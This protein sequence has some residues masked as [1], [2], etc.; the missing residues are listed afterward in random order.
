MWWRCDGQGLTGGA[1]CL[2]GWY[3][4]TGNLA[5]P[6]RSNVSKRRCAMAD[7]LF[8]GRWCVVDR[9]TASA[10]SRGVGTLNLL[11]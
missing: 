5:F 1:L 8:V 7:M 6:T 9:L 2:V 10:D 11:E 4:G 3:L